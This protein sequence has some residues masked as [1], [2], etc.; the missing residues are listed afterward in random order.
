MLGNCGPD[1]AS[2]ASHDTKP[3]DVTRHVVGETPCFFLARQA[4]SSSVV[5][6]SS[7]M[8]VAYIS[9]QMSWVTQESE[10][11]EIVVSLR[12]GLDDDPTARQGAF[13]EKVKIGL[14]QHG[15]DLDHGMDGEVSDSQR[16]QKR[17][18]QE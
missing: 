8:H 16:S 14:R 12:T 11:S 1:V 15:L 2:Q 10:L 5:D 9:A 4:K 13:R 17:T 6:S 7:S 18:I 3:P